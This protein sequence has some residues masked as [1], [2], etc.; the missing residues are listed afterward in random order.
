MSETNKYPLPNGCRDEIDQWLWDEMQL[1]P[2]CCS[3]IEELKHSIAREVAE[4]L[5]KNTW[6]SVEDEL[7]E[8]DGVYFVL[9]NS[10]IAS[11]TPFFA[12]TK[13]FEIG[14]FNFN[15]THWMPIP[16]L[17]DK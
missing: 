11:V 13:Q 12:K 2:G 4:K 5:W 17:E 7:P 16:K 10:K 14:K 15:V 3:S 1:L 9:I 6:I 8:K